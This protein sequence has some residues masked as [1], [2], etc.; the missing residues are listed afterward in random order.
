MQLKKDFND[1][2]IHQGITSSF[3]IYKTLIIMG[4]ELIHHHYY[5]FQ[6]EELALAH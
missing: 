3:I 4:S 1:E 6:L 2:V 5:L